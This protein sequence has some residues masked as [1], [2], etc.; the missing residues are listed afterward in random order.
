MT[1]KQRKEFYIAMQP[2]FIH[3]FPRS[4]TQ[5]R[6]RTLDLILKYGLLL[7]PEV[8]TFPKE[9][10]HH[11]G[12][13]KKHEADVLQRRFCLTLL[14]DLAHLLRFSEIFGQF[15][16]QFSFEVARKKL[17]AI[18]VFYLA[19]PFKEQRGFDAIGCTLIHRLAEIQDI[20]SNLVEIETSVN[21]PSCEDGIF[22]LS[23]ELNGCFQFKQKDLEFL[24]KVLKNQASVPVEE[25]KN[26]IYYFSNFFVP[27]EYKGREIDIDNIDAKHPYL[28]YYKQ[29]EWRILGDMALDGQPS[30][31]ELTL[32]EKSDF[33]ELN[34]DCFAKPLN[35][36]GQPRVI[37]KCRIIDCTIDGQPVRELIENIY[38]PQSDKSEA[39]KILEKYGM[40]ERLRTI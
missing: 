27:T 20:F 1:S 2:V 23:D 17:G 31:R 16:I 38:V 7:A 22:E 32:S 26:W 19:N 40:S 34:P 12:I 29:R 11:S 8:L 28:E 4:D 39:N 36:K 13:V 24:L 14:D 15:H 37:E 33:L 21:D 6:F 3:T 18:P 5:C 9:Y 30:D 25:L 35:W 10:D